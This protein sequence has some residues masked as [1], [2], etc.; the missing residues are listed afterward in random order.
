MIRGADFLC[1]VME[2]QRLP[3]DLWWQIGLRVSLHDFGALART[4]KRISLIGKGQRGVEARKRFTVVRHYQIRDDS[5]EM[6]DAC[7]YLLNGR[8]H[9]ENDEPA[10]CS[11]CGCK[12]WYV[13]GKIIRSVY[14]K[15]A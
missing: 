3:V 4:C 8:R 10:F 7:E 11:F 13:H 15:D 2:W 1:S 12:R 6:M 9:R 5:F 14:C